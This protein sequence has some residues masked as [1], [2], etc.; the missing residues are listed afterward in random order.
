MASCDHPSLFLIREAPSVPVI[1]VEGVR[2]EVKVTN[3]GNGTYRCK[4]RPKSA[5]EAV[6]TLS[7]GGRSVP[8]F[9][10]TV[11]VRERDPQH[12]VNILKFGLQHR[13][14]QFV[15]HVGMATPTPLVCTATMTREGAQP[16]LVKVA[17]GEQEGVFVCRYTP[18][19]VGEYVVR[20]QF[21]G[22]DAFGP[23]VVIVRKAA[24]G[25]CSW[26]AGP[27]LSA[28]S[29][30]KVN[31]FTVYTRGDDGLPLAGAKCQAWMK[32]ANAGLNLSPVAIKVKEKGDGSYLCEYTPPLNGDF[33]VSASVDGSAVTGNPGKTKGPRLEGPGARR[34][35]L[36]RV[37][38]FVVV[39]AEPG[40]RCE[41]QIRNTK[42]Q[43]ID[44][45]VEPFGEG[46][47]LCKYIPTAV[48]GDFKLTVTLDSQAFG[49]SVNLKTRRAAN[50]TNSWAEGQ[51]KAFAGSLNRFVVHAR[52]DDGKPVLHSDCRVVMLPIDS[53]Y[54][55]QVDV[56][57]VDNGD[58]TFDCRYTPDLPGDFAITLRIDD[59]IVKVSP[60]TVRTFAQS[61]EPWAE[62]PGLV[63]A[64]LGRPNT[65]NIH[66]PL[67]AEDIRF[68][69]WL[70][71]P[72]SKLPVADVTITR[73]GELLRQCVY[74]PREEGKFEV[75]LAANGK[76]IGNS[77]VL[78]NVRKSA[79]TDRSM[80]RALIN[81]SEFIVSAFDDQNK[82][83]KGCEC[84]AFLVPKGS[85]VRLRAFVKDNGDGNYACTYPHPPEGEFCVAVRLD[86]H[87]LRPLWINGE[88][89]ESTA[90]GFPKVGH[91]R[92]WKS[93]KKSG[94][95]SSAASSSAAIPYSE[96]TLQTEQG[97]SDASPSSQSMND[98]ELIDHADMGCLHI[99]VFQPLQGRGTFRR[100][101]W[102]YYL[103]CCCSRDPGMG[104]TVSCLDCCLC[105]PCFAAFQ[106]RQFLIS[107]A[108]K[109]P[110]NN[111]ERCS[112]CCC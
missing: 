48:T 58:G 28:A 53:K 19:S 24:L 25:S 22:V 34:A 41:A 50:A 43:T 16:V 67:A 11:A 29:R 81:N 55:H 73:V 62:G 69:G 106:C 82:P 30:G 31:H 57:V 85:N 6:V 110:N 101:D 1:R 87:E 38:Q 70:E 84:E 40:Q 32:P 5:G 71:D 14:N 27:G 108:C 26:S 90:G 3:K 88:A 4:F 23:L 93:S 13:V 78:V 98:D 35:L 42:E 105:C 100:A 104:K 49:P 47:F 7:V 20:V 63:C 109:K 112:C 79:N 92:S 96:S 80:V 10:C 66:A 91:V 107:S 51:S 61:L 97:K 65:F 75:R 17:A 102:G 39:G 45:S 89:S 72:R 9:P 59:S 60:V 54:L 64:L 95:V 83:V 18:D 46:S 21:D 36:D 37:N 44:V 76:D 8:G 86:G 12:W 68:V 74:T 15:V 77:P 94:I 103:C 56:K 111:K 33:V 52:G 99:S 2:G